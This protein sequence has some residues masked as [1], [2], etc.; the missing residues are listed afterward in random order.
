[1][2]K[3]SEPI[4]APTLEPIDERSEYAKEVANNE[5][6]FKELVRVVRPDIYVL[7]DILDKT[8][9][10]TLML[11]QVIRSA[12]SIAMGSQYGKVVVQI[13]NGV[14]TFV[15]GEESKKLNELLVRPEIKIGSN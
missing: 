5:Y 14:V 7:M 15:H 13:E 4:K 1:M 2:K 3:K 8:R 9:I 12:N 11:F 10:N 6:V